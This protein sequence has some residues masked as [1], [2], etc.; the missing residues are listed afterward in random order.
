MSY[1]Q[2]YVFQK[3]QKTN[4]KALNMITNTDEA[5]TTIEHISCDCKYKFNSTKCNSNQKW[6][7]KISQC[8]CKNGHRF[9]NDYRWNPSTCFSENSKYLKS[10]GDTS[11]TN[12]DD[13]F[14]MDLVSTKKKNAIATNVASTAYINCHSKNIRDPYILHTVLLVIILLLVTIIISYHYAKPRCTI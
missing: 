6:N 11:V 7:N 14:V 12:C 8:E 3:K 2:K 10:A 5:K 1:S 9:Q 4:V 13:V